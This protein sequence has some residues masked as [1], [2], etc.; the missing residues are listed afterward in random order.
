MA[1]YTAKRSKKSK[2]APSNKV[3]IDNWDFI[4]NETGAINDHITKLGTIQQNDMC[5][6]SVRELKSKF[7]YYH[8]A[9]KRL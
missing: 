5:M 8:N 6:V 1:T 4:S 3:A 9:C 2:T 7:A